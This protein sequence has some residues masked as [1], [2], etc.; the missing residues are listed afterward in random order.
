VIE[1]LADRDIT[2]FD[3]ILKRNIYEVMTHLAY[4]RDYSEEQK[5]ITGLIQRRHV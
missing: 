2:K 5:R 3:A 1:T 4:L